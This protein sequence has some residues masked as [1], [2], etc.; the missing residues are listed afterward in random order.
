M[1]YVYF[2]FDGTLADSVLLGVEIANYLAPKFGFE[3]ADMSKIDY[4]RTLSA[5]E[6][7]KEFKIPLFKLPIVAPAFKI[8]LNK[9][10]DQ[11][12][13]YEG[14][15]I[16]LKELSLKYKVGVLTSNSVENVQK[17]LTKNDTIKYV[18]DIRSEFQ[19]FGK[20]LSLR[21]IIS[22]Y[23]IDKKDFIY[24]GDETRDIEATKKVKI[25]SIA[26]TWG[27]N[28]EDVLRKFKP[29]FVAHT[30]ADVVSFVNSVFKK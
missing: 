19:V 21:K 24:V 5:Q 18:S 25:S 2:D 12:L 4:Y 20:H 26:V 1:Q 9:R 28:S 10:L 23:K 6:I 17:F 29:T 15:D 7:L 13:A 30:P 3:S 22:K 14:V 16:M 27:I 8:E 11:L